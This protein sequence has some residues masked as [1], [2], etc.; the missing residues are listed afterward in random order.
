MTSRVVTDL[1]PW[2][3]WFAWEEVRIG[4]LGLEPPYTLIKGAWVEF[5]IAYRYWD[6]VLYEYRETANQ[7][8]AP[9]WWRLF[10]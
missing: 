9:W 5:R 7:T 4:P 8:P 2:E 10:H 1:H 3:R 6:V